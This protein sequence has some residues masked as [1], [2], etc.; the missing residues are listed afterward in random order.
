[1]FPMFE[2]NVLPPTVAGWVQTTASP[3]QVQ[4]I[5]KIFSTLSQIETAIKNNFSE[6]IFSRGLVAVE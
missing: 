4:Q 5:E 2:Q 1:M 3:T 6:N